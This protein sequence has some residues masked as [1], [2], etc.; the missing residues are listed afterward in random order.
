[1]VK[2]GIY[3]PNFGTGMEPGIMAEL[4]VEAE[5]AGWDGFFI[6]DHVLY[7]KSQRL[8]ILDPW[9]TLSTIAVRTEKIK[10]GALLTPIARRRP[11][12]L[13]RET[14]TLDRLS[15]GRLIFAAGLG[16]PVD[17]E[18]ERFGEEGNE[19]IIAEKLDEGLD[20]LTGLW[21]GKNFKY[22]GKHFQVSPTTFLPTPIQQPRIPI[23]IGGFW[24]NKPPIRRAARWDGV[25]P[26][27]TGGSIRASDINKI[28]E[29][30]SLYRKSDEP[31]DIIV[32]GKTPSEDPEKTNKK[33]RPFI[34]A[35]LTWWLE[36]IYGFR[37]DPD[38]MLKRI[39]SGPPEI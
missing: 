6:W 32:T 39:K 28:K 37:N 13:A 3:S 9:I 27:K 38:A 30:I 25:F 10:I 15:N 19:K 20:I 12:K 36:S 23:W 7:S 5:A 31:Y 17:A 4:A 1:M 35:G 18:Y 2:F 16:A 26:L 21:R 34:R 11:W 8:T 14:A 22:Q 24:P 33:I 29:Y